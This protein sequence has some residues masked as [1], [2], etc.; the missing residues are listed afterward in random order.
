MLF[1]V[2]GVYIYS[3][4]N[5]MLLLSVLHIEQSEWYA[6]AQCLLIEQSKWHATAQCLQSEWHATAKCLQF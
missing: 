5:G 6:S 2:F 4:H 1:S 3:S